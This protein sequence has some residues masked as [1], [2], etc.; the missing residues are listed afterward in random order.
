MFLTFPDIAALDLLKGIRIDIE[1][2]QQKY[3][4][5]DSTNDVQM[6]VALGVKVAP[7]GYPNLHLLIEPDETD[8]SEPIRKRV[9]RICRDA[10]KSFDWQQFNLRFDSDIEPVL[11][12]KIVGGLGECGL[13]AKIERIAPR[14]TEDANRF[15]AL[16]GRTTK[17]EVW[18]S[19]QANVGRAERVRMQGRVEVVSLAMARWGS[20]EAKDFG[21]RTDSRMNETRLREMAAERSLA[22]PET[23]PLPVDERRSLA[24]ELELREIRD[25]VADTLRESMTKVPDLAAN[26]RSLEA[27]NKIIGWAEDL[28]TK[29]IEKEFGLKV[30]LRSVFRHDTA[31]EGLAQIEQDK[32]AELGGKLLE[33]DL[34]RE[35]AL[36]QVA[37][38]HQ[39]NLLTTAGTREVQL[40]DL[41]DN[42]ESTK[43]RAAAA[44]QLRGGASAARLTADSVAERLKQPEP[45][46][47][48]SGQLPWLQGKENEGEASS[49]QEDRAGV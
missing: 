45:Q 25:R 3:S 34:A 7:G 46:A 36:R 40:L 43:L 12:R 18:L 19:S 16:C 48:A 23:S 49:G 9:C 27:S 21:Y 32:A 22:L 35:L 31:A 29:A 6:E 33:H 39:V 41:E 8:I 24:I 13:A 1:P 20:F 42:E 30:A 11:H 10:L 26:W 17:F 2:D 47:A 4:L 5:K 15:K 28:A 38:Q 44:Q 37:D 14:P